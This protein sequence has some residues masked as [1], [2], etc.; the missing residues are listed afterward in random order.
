MQITFNG[1]AQWSDLQKPD[2]YN[3]PECNRCRDLADTKCQ[4]HLHGPTGWVEGPGEDPTR[5]VGSIMIVALGI[6]CSVL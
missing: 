2:A 5:T 1:G 3:H 6:T 4:L